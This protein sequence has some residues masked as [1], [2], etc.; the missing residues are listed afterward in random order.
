MD[1]YHVLSRGVEKRNV[2]QDDKDRLRFLHDLYVFNDSSPAE[3]YILSS[4]QDIRERNKLVAIHAFCLMSN[5]YHLLL[6]PLV[7]NGI[8]LFIKKLNMGYAKY[9]NEKYDRSGSLWQGKHKKILIDRDAH[10]MYI[11]YYIHLNPLDA[12]FPEWRK[13]NI[14]NTQKA[15]DFLESYRWSSYLDYIGK[16]NFPSIIDRNTLNEILTSPTSIKNEMKRIV[17]DPYLSGASDYLE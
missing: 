7:E 12:K 4:R 13:G 14:K 17:S 11:P 5:H 9:F 8:S 3:N 15:F 6:S 10:F 1:F 16:R 2:V